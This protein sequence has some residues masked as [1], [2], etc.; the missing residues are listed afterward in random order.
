MRLQ[1]NTKTL[2]GVGVKVKNC[3]PNLSVIVQKGV[4]AGARVG[5]SV[6]IDVGVGACVMVDMGEGA[7]MGWERS[8]GTT[9]AVV[10]V[11]VV[12][13]VVFVCSLGES[14]ALRGSGVEMFELCLLWYFS[15]RLLALCSLFCLSLLLSFAMISEMRQRVLQ[16]A[17]SSH[18]NVTVD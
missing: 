7:S 10:K 15:C 1:Q 11:M 12:A 16:D 13:P 4:G 9:A 18:R 3:E 8:G 14:S 17:N 5:V 6:G 2:A